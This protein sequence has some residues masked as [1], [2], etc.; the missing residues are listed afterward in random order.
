MLAARIFCP[1]CGQALI[2][3]ENAPPR[4]TCPRCL[5]VVTNPASPHAGAPRPVLPLDT[6][7]ER[8]MRGAN[9]VLVGL[10]VILGLATLATYRAGDLTGFRFVLSASSGPSGEPC[11]SNVSCL[12]GEP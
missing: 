11:A 2:V 8:D 7:A 5:S 3:A 6:Q 1:S 12:S 10:L 9:W 4:V